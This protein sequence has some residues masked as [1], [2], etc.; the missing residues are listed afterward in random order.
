MTLALLPEVVRLEAFRP[1]KQ[2]IPRY[3]LTPG[4][5]R[6]DFELP[7]FEFTWEE[8]IRQSVTSE[9]AR[10]KLDQVVEALADRV[11][12]LLREASPRTGLA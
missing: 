7:G 10:R 5:E 12:E 8:D 2:A 6:Y 9:E 3:P 4:P 11:R 1:G